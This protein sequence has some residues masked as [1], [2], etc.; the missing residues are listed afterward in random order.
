MAF[1][2]RF[3]EKIAE[4]RCCTM[5]EGQGIVILNLHCIFMKLL[6]MIVLNRCRIEF[7]TCSCICW[8][9]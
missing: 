3:N 5:K 9:N 6:L 2:A 8:G 1:K 7:S 4:N